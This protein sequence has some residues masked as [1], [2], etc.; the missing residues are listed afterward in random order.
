MY[1]LGQ[2]LRP[3]FEAKPIDFKEVVEGNYG[4]TDLKAY[5]EYKKK[6]WEQGIT[7]E[8]VDRMSPDHINSCSFWEYI[9]KNPQLAKDAIAFGATQD[10]SYELVNQHNYRL[11]CGLGTLNYVWTFIQRLKG[12]FKLV[13][14]GLAYHQYSM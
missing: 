13:R 4:I 1:Q 11:A 7:K 10:T 9:E 12:A 3:D 14:M 5:D 6:M 8:V 2:P